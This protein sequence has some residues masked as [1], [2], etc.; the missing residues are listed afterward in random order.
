MRM[1]ELESPKRRVLL[2]EKKICKDYS[3]NLMEGTIINIELNS[4]YSDYIESI[5]L[6]IHLH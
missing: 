3:D 6:V 2:I 5:V 1:K 4:R